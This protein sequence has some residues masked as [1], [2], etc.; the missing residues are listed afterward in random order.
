MSISDV[1]TT[2]TNTR[3]ARRGRAARMRKRNASAPLASSI[4]KRNIPRYPVLHSE[5]LEA[6]EEQA[7]WIL[8]EVGIEFRGDEEALRLFKEAGADVQGERIRFEEGHVT[9]LCCTA[10]ES[11][12]MESRQ[13][14]HSIILGG[15]HIVLMPGYGS[16]FVTDLDKGR[17][18]ATLE[19]FITS[20]NS[21]TNRP[22]YIMAAVP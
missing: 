13:A 5:A 2:P 20:S 1:N 12:R 11:F 18:Y 21:L 7:D 22:C 10:P 8:K 16:P 17:R 3:P 14:E 4:F 15:D 6:I 9:N 19:D